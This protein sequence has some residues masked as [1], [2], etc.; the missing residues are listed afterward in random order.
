MTHDHAPAHPSRPLSTLLAPIRGQLIA[1]AL[2][3]ALGAALS[4]VPLAGVAALG[5][6]LLSEQ[7]SPWSSGAI[8]AV[9][10]ACLFASGVFSVLAELLAH[11]AD[12]RITGHLRLALA[13]HLMQVPLGW[14][15]GR[16]SS[17]VKRA[18]QD[19]IG[20]LHSLVA[21]FFTTLGRVL[22]AVTAAVGYL[23]LMDWRLALLALLPFP[24]FVL[25][26][27]RAMA[28]S[29]QHMGPLGERIAELENAVV[30]FVNGM[31]VLKAFGN[32]H[33][34]RYQ[35]AVSGFA[36]AFDQFT[37]PLVVAMAKA[38]AL[39]APATVLGVVLIGAVLM[40][41]LGWMT[42]LQVLPFVL[43]TPGL[44][45]PLL[46]LHA[47]THDLHNAVAAAQRVLDLLHTP[48][49]AQPVRAQHPRDNELRVEGL[50]FA[51]DAQKPIL[52][53]I[54]FTL[55]P[56]TTT[57][58]VGPSGSGKSTLARLLLRFHDPSQGRIT[59]GGVDV[60][61]IDSATLY[62]RI[63]FVLQ[64]VR[65]LRASI[66]DNIALGRP[67]ASQADIEA[68]A[69]VANIHQR[70]LQ[71]PRGYDAVIDDDAVL[72]GGERQRLSIARAVLIDPPLLVLDEPTAAVDAEGEVALQEALARFAKGRS[73]LVIAHRLDTVMHA[74]QI[75]L[76]ERGVICERGSH[77]EL[78]AAHGRYARLWALGDYA[79]A[80]EH[81]CQ[82]PPA[83]APAPC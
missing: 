70:I 54:D 3:A 12:N 15:G 68:A 80:L 60:R 45:A 66:R 26:L 2:L 5:A 24:G 35:R 8:I 6:N 27:R 36:H 63:G 65:L 23:M 48:V 31:P 83:Q 14:F 34:P 61:H 7:A 74:E 37:R 4:L 62:G 58:V 9:S 71:L 21:H 17:A 72:S 77:A 59:L 28:A 25:F 43:V 47:I 39:I 42:P 79:S 50:G 82:Q 29:A 16:S 76:L 32:R 40:V 75:L 81:D 69:Q 10:V 53:G 1:A 56:G 52:S 18:L 20:T 13:R 55:Q 57:A 49:L 51:Y 67:D 46:L 19:D 44:C 64:D 33:D 11:L 41:A 30:E 22:G 78:L 73:V 38:N